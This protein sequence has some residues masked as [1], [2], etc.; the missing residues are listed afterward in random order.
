MANTNS[1]YHFKNSFH[2]FCQ[3]IHFLTRWIVA[4]IVSELSPASTTSISVA[5]SQ[6]WLKTHSLNS[7]YRSWILFFD[8][9]LVLPNILISE[10]DS[11]VQTM[12]HNDQTAA[13]F[14]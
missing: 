8:F 6:R 11:R 3:C 5:W 4:P 10:T 7:K 2:T 14:K 9:I 1:L 12:E 13:N